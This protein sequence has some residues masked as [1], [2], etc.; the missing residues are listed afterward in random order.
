VAQVF[1]TGKMAT[2]Y[3]VHFGDTT[4]P[5]L[6][7]PMIAET[8]RKPLQTNCKLPLPRRG[9][10]AAKINPSK[11]VLAGLGFFPLQ[12]KTKTNLNSTELNKTI[13]DIESWQCRTRQARPAAALTCRPL[14]WVRRSVIELESA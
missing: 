8:S 6:G 9:D 14:R 2:F 3:L 13:L 7:A 12:I 1:F 5:L 11:F 10:T 4:F